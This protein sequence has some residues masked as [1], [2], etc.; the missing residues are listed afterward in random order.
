[1]AIMTQNTK[2]FPPVSQ[3]GILPNIASPPIQPSLPISSLV[4][5]DADLAV[6]NDPIMQAE[7][8]VQGA[9]DVLNPAAESHKIPYAT[10]GDIYKAVIDAMKAQENGSGDNVDNDA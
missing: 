2:L 1:M 5:T 7:N 6:P 9:L 8:N 3:A 10:D 4:H